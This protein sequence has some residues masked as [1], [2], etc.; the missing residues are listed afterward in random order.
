[1]PD[2]PPYALVA[3]YLVKDFDHWLATF[4]SNQP[5]R[6]EAGFLGHHVNRA[7]EDPNR[8]ALYLAATDLDKG[9]AFLSSPELREVM[10]DAGIVSPPE[11]NWMVPK[12]TDIVWEGELPSMIATHSV[13]DF[14]AWFEG[15]NA[16]DELRAAN[17]IVGHAANQS[18]D[19]PL[20]V[21]VYHQAASFDTL[22]AFLALPELQAAMEAAGVTSEPEVQFCTGGWARQY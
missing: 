9:N 22:R 21:L 11:F 12:R 2:L 15:Y 6:V 18:L 17:G 20:R 4:D 14:D 3:E 5:M 19:D 1:M 13:A 10:Q 8:I 16:T 7:E